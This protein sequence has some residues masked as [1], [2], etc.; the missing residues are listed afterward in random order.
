MT[1][2]NSVLTI[3]KAQ[4]GYRE[5]YSGGNW[6][7]IEKYAPQVPGLEWAQGQPWC[8]VFVSWVAMKAGAAA[9]YPR[10]ASVVAAEAWWKQAGRW[11]EYPAV[12]AQV[13]FGTSGHTHTGIVIAYDAT[14]ITTVEGNTNNDGSAEGNGVYLKTRPRTDP[15]ITGYGY[16]KFPEGIHAADPAYAKETPVTLPPTRVTKARA[17]LLAIRKEL[18]QARAVAGPVRRSKLS[19]ALLGIRTALLALPQR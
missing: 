9:L 8:A 17:E 7:N 2:C 1:V 6:N 4:V 15:W 3:A 16:P 14:T 11:S 5:G 18:R 13:I 19:A 12:G 10:T